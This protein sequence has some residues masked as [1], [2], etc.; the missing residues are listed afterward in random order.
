[1]MMM[2]LFSWLIPSQVQAADTVSAVKRMV[3]SIPANTFCDQSHLVELSLNVTNLSNADQK[4]KLDFLKA[5]GTSF[6]TA[7]TTYNG[8]TSELIP[9]SGVAVAAGHASTYHFTFGGQ[10][11]N[12]GDRPFTGIL[13]TSGSSNAELIASGFVNSSLYSVPI[14]INGG[15]EWLSAPQTDSTEPTTPT[16]VPAPT[17]I[18][19]PVDQCSVTP[20]NSLIHAMTANQDVYGKASS[21][22]YDTSWDAQAYHAFDNKCYPFSTKN[23]EIQGWLSYEFT[24]AKTVTSYSMQMK[25]NDS[26]YG[27]A[28][29]PKSWVFEAYDGKAWVTLDSQTGIKTWTT[30]KANVYTIPNTTAYKQYRIRFLEN[31]GGNLIC[32]S[33][34][35]MM[36]Y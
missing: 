10:T 12:C 25:Q 20:V 14:I 3:F 24:D 18:N 22:S 35:G 19:Q 17:P 8:M 16:P 5:D 1:M 2:M 29:A 36:G 28:Q 15:M 30:D 31:N 11:S 4:V 6:V 27:L 26:Q 23:G 9:G 13:T 21:S 7:G 32:I 33:E 34:M